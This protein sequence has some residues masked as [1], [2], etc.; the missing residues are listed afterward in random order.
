MSLHEQTVAF[1]QQLLIYGEDVSV[2]HFTDADEPVFNSTTEE[3]VPGSP[4]IVVTKAFIKE[5]TKFDIDASY[6]KVTEGSKKLVVKKSLLVALG[7]HVTIDADTTPYIVD[8]LSPK[9]NR[10]F[11]FCSKNE[12]EPT[13]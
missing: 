8:Q 13:A 6:G 11:V 3:L 12:E 5:P 10:L 7:D 1:E 9:R 2:S 4:S